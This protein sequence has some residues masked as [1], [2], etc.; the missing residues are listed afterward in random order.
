VFRENRLK[1]RLRNQQPSLGMWLQSADATFA[2]IAGL[3]GFDFVI[4]DQEHGPGTIMAAIAMMR[5]LSATPTTAMIRVPSSDPVYLKR[6]MDAGAEAVL[7]P[8]VESAEEARMVVDACRYPPQ[9]KRGNAAAVSRGSG[10]GFAGDYLARAHEQLLVV[11]QIETV[12]GVKNAKAIAEVDG[13]DMIFIGPSD[14]AGSAGVPGRTGAPEVEALIAETIAA[15]RPTGKPLSTVP[16]DGKS[17]QDLFADGFMAVPSGSD[18][19][20][21]RTAAAA[22][23]EEWR[24]Y[25]AKPAQK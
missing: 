21:F 19:F 18:I 6:I 8:M 20:F 11:P 14:L 24:S 15:V 1:T 25:Q 10:Y 22:L 9:G 5:A 2:E 4:I 3:A 12:A 13:I 16:R 7:V 23:G 17:W